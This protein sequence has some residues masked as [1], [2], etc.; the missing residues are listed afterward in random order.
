MAKEI[1]VTFPGNLKVYAEVDGFEIKTDQPE[2]D[3]GNGTAPAPSSFFTASIATCTGYF[4]LKFCKARNIETEG[5]T[6]SM[7]YN[8]DAENKRYPEMDIL[9]T[10]PPGFPAKYKDAIVRAMEQCVVKRNILEPPEFHIAASLSDP[11]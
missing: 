9:L 10:L 11:S 4:A 5:M 7:K 6:L 1:N 8:W 3:G 2:E